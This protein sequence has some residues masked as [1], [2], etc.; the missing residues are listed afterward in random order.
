MKN[1]FFLN[2]HLH[3]NESRFIFLNYWTVGLRWTLTP[4]GTECVSHPLFKAFPMWC[5]HVHCL[6]MIQIALLMGVSA[7]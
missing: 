4:Y 2:Y 7:I 1:S 6:V 3:V 5:T